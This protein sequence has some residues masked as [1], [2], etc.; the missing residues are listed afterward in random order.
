MTVTPS[1]TLPVLVAV[2]GGGAIGSTLRFGATYALRGISSTTGWPVGTLAV[3]IAGS[4]VLG[5]FLARST[6]GASVANDATRA[7]VAA[8]VLGGFTTFSAF[9]GEVL[10]YLNAA[11][12]GR[13]SLY[14]IASVGLSVGAAALG[15]A[16][17]RGAA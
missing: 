10:A 16:L 12:F 9:S 11:Q 8:G 6:G 5:W 1:L 7:F 3:N 13:A 17:A 2:A 14:A 4:M 15:F